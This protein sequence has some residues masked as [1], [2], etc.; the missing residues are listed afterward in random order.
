MLVDEGAIER[1]GERWVV[2]ANLAAFEMIVP[3]TNIV[4]ADIQRGPLDGWLAAFR[5]RG[6]LAVPFGRGRMRMVTHLNITKED[7]D[8]AL[9]RVREAVEAVAV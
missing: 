7:I 1:Q 3:Q 6:V 2:G 9:S 8:E 5:E 4:L